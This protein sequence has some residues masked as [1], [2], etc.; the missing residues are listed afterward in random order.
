MVSSA[1]RRIRVTMVGLGLVL[2]GACGRP[3]AASCVPTLEL[4]LRLRRRADVDQALAHDTAQRWDTIAM[5]SLRFRAL[6]PAAE[7]PRLGELSP[8]TWLAPCDEDDVICLQEA[9]EAER[10]LAAALGDLQ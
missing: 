10:E 5:A 9:A 7:L 6:N 2:L 8:E 3:G 4:G 1:A